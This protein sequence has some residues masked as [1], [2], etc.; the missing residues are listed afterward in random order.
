M[1]NAE[2]CKVD[3]MEKLGRTATDILHEL[4]A[5]RAGAGDHGPSLSAVYRTMRG[6][7]YKR[8][9]TERRGRPAK[10]PPGLVEAAEE[11]RL[12]L[13]EGRRTST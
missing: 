7:S 5:V 6:K 11:A 2:V 9:A 8:G 12:N 10:L 1:S 3:E 13:A 4:R